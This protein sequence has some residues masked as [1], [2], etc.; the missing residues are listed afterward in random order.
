[1]GF[2][3]YFIISKQKKK[4]KKESNLK[5]STRISIHP[6]EYKWIFN[7]IHKS[8][9][10]GENEKIWG[11]IGFCWKTM[12]WPHRPHSTVGQ[13]IFILIKNPSLQEELWSHSEK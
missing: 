7:L 11:H 13:T 10:M 12:E 8:L 9:R 2:G 3:C 5:S 6:V 4:K 1:M